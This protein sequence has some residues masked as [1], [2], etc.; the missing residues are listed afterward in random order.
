MV[1]LL[2]VELSTTEHKI[3]EDSASNTPWKAV[4]MF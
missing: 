4:D 1:S 3:D 2:Y